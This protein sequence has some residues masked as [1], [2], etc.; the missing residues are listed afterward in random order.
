MI[1]LKGADPRTV[2]SAK[3]A[4]SAGLLRPT[5]VGSRA[6]ISTPHRMCGV[7][8]PD[9]INY[10]PLVGYIGYTFRTDYNNRS[11]NVDFG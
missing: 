9:A 3:L 6:R 10:T 5:Y 8:I 11:G 1:R 7:H 4:S 2:E